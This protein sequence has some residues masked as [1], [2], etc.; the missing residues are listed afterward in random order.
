MAYKRGNITKQ[1][2]LEHWVLT[3]TDGDGE[4]HTIP[5]TLTGKHTR[6]QAQRMCQQCMPAG[7]GF[8]SVDYVRTEYIW[9][10]MTLAKFAALG[11]PVDP[12]VTINL[13]EEDKK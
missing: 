12:P 8:V 2:P 3:I 6:A 9:R 11:D 1:I 4:E 10:Q 13:N 7:A 5:V